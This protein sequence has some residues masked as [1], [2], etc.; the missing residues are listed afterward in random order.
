[1]HN[2]APSAVVADKEYEGASYS[3]PLSFKR[4]P[5]TP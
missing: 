1:M 3:L 2:L 4:G 5:A